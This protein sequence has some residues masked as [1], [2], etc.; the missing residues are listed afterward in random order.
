MRISASL[1]AASILLLISASSSMAQTRSPWEMH[2]GLEVT[3]SNPDGL[4]QFSCSPAQHGD[5][6]EYDV[7]TIPASNDAGWGAA[8]NGA[9]IGFSIPSRVC[10]APNACFAYGDFTYFQTLVDIPASIIVTTF[11]I[12]FSGMDDGC[13]VTIFNSAYPAG[14]VVPGSYVFLG[15]S[16]TTNLRD[17]VVSGEINRVVVT[18]VDDCCSEN[19][20]QSAIVV[21]NGEPVVVGV[22]PSSWS[23]VK[24]NY[25]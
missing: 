1:A 13:R 2:D 3:I 6:C 23:R 16:G 5:P 10:N 22:S 12:A 18:Q 7:A 9:T 24:S 15:G 20:L 17:Y 14:L 25:R 11:T 8:P 4:V 21:L 19:N